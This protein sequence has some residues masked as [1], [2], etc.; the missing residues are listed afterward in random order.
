MQPL[1][2]LIFLLKKNLFLPIFFPDEKQQNNLYLKKFIFC[3]LFLITVKHISIQRTQ[4]DGLKQRKIKTPNCQISL[5][6]VSDQ[7]FVI[8]F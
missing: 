3:Y 6:Q 5:S 4:R 1:Q 2:F 8:I 7:W